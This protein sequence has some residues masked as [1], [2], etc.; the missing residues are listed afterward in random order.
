MHIVII[1]LCGHICSHVLFVAYWYHSLCV[2]PQQILFKGA[3]EWIHSEAADS[4]KD[5]P[6]SCIIPLIFPVSAENHKLANS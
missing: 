6:Y 4:Y 1:T 3:G 2:P 5:Y